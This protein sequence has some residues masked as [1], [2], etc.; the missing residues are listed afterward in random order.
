MD[1]PEITASFMLPC[2]S[3]AIR[4]ASS[5]SRVPKPYEELISNEQL[6][7]R[8]AETHLMLELG[9]IPPMDRDCRTVNMQL[10]ND[11]AADII[12]LLA[13]V[14]VHDEF[15]SERALHGTLS[16]AK[17]PY[18]DIALWVFVGQEGLPS[19]VSG[20]ISS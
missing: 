12:L 3:L 15:R 19:T 20:V 17:Q 5:I 14:L 16:Q 4:S 8:N 1:V 10:T 13:F 6:S 18:E 7:T 9:W 2:S 11:T